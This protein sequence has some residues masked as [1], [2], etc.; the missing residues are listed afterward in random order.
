MKT[1]ILT[2]T[3]WIFFCSSAWARIE[4]KNP[5][6]EF[7][8]I[9]SITPLD[10]SDSFDSLQVEKVKLEKY[11]QKKDSILEQVSSVLNR[12][13]LGEQV[14]YLTIKGPNV[15]IYDGKSTST[16]KIKQV[17]INIHEGSIFSIHLTTD[18]NKVYLNKKSQISLNSFNRRARDRIREENKGTTGYAELGEFLRYQS[19]YGRLTLPDDTVVTLIPNIVD[20]AFLKLDPS[21][22]NLIEGRIYSD[23]MG[24]SGKAN[25]II[26]TELYTRFLGNTL[27]LPNSRYV[28]ANFVAPYFL[29]SKFDSEFDTIALNADTSISRMRLIQLAPIHYGI[30]FNVLSYFRV[31]RFE[32]NFGLQGSLTRNVV[33]PDSTVADINQY[34]C[35]FQIGGVVTRGKNYGLEFSAK[36]Y[37]SKLADRPSLNPVLNPTA[38]WVLSPE[39]NLFWFPGNDKH[40]KIFFRYRGFYNLTDEDTNFIQLQLGYSFS[41][42]KLFK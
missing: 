18:D 33:F 27:N 9:V 32:L 41:I 24:L 13:V 26:Q 12:K 5:K 17:D 6:N 21:I 8:E 28:P 36:V 37:R 15:N 22:S 19:L 29:Y 7:S 10:S 1:L 16:K 30:T 20:T 40:N 42:N 4:I 2:T 11:V 38:I 23:V 35:Y 3:M 39:A 14:G 31:Y 34:S 25:G